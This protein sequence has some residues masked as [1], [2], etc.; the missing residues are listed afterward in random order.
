MFQA[1]SSNSFRDILLTSIKCPNFQRA[2][3]PKNKVNFLKHLFNQ[4][5]YSSSP[6]SWPSLKPL[7]QILFEIS[8]WQILKS[9]NFQ[10]AITPEK[11][12]EF[13]KNFYQVIYSSSLISWP[14]FKP[15]AQIL[16][17]ISCWQDFIL[18][19]SKGHNSRN[20]DK[21]DKKKNTGRLFFHEES[22]YEISKP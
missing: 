2:I 21:A 18:I 22:I 5:I 10:R 17:E 7:A 8:C 1:P 14:S 13:L 12:G 11:L 20:G 19:F 4:V 15:L 9:P 16:F 3:T 6:I